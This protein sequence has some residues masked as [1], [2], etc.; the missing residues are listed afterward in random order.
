[1]MMELPES[2][3]DLATDP[4]RVYYSPLDDI[5]FAPAINDFCARARP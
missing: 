3:A 4:T 2:A 5:G 1:M